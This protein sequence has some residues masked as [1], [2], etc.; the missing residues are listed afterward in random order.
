MTNA[1]IFPLESFFLIIIGF[2][3]IVVSLFLIQSSWYP[4]GGCLLFIGIPSI[5]L[6]LSMVLICILG[7]ILYIIYKTQNG[8]NP[9]SVF[10]SQESLI[11]IIPLIFSLAIL[12]ITLFEWSS[13]NTNLIVYDFG[14][15]FPILVLFHGILFPSLIIVTIFYSLVTTRNKL[16]VSQGIIHIKQVIEMIKEGVPVPIN[17]IS[18]NSHTNTYVTEKLLK[19]ILTS[20]SAGEYL[21]F[22]KVFIKSNGTIEAIDSLL[23]SYINDK[24]TKL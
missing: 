16:V 23:D 8:I 21:E 18:K 20:N 9:D 6:F 12:I 5:L 14:N 17:Q 2:Y 3:G 13:L 24:N 15:N 4:C 7:L 19:S 10:Y 1:K 22:E 11:L